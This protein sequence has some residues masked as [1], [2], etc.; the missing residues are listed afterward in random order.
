[1]FSFN[2]KLPIKEKF[3]IDNIV[4]VVRNN[5]N[6][7]YFKLSIRPHKTSN[8]LVT[9]TTLVG[10]FKEMKFRK[11]ET[12]NL[13]LTTCEQTDHEKDEDNNVLVV[14]LER[15]FTQ[16]TKN[17]KFPKEMVL[18]L[19]IKSHE[20]FDAMQFRGIIS[21]IQAHKEKIEKLKQKN[22]F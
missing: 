2:Q 21:F 6:L 4:D 18:K 12:I 15:E 13:D 9:M 17:I 10:L 8:I 16:F 1:M 22:A 5:K 14:D 7:T 11:L 19:N 20:K 3:S